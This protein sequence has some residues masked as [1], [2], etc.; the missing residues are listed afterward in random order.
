MLW[1]T[2]RT[3]LFLLLVSVIALAA[4]ETLL[5][6]G[7]KSVGGAATGWRDEILKTLL[8]PWIWAGVVLLLVHL[9]FY[10]AALGK[11]DLSLVLPLTAASYPLTSLLAQIYLDERVGPTRWLGTA[12]ITAGVAVVGFGDAM[13]RR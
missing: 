13:N 6:K 12:L 7:M 10:M 1:K 9:V 8:S 3:V 2:R 11:A 5:A 4:G